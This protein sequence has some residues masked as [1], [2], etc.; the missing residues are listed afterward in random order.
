MSC[1]RCPAMPAALRLGFQ[2]FAF[3]PNRDRHR[4]DWKGVRFRIATGHRSC[5]IKLPPV[6]VVFGGCAPL[7]PAATRHKS[8]AMQ[9]RA[10]F[11][12][13]KT[14]IDRRFARI[15]ES[16]RIAKSGNSIASILG[17]WAGLR[18]P[19]FGNSLGHFLKRIG[20]KQ[21]RAHGRRNWLE[22]P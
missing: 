5:R 11:R 22:H 13:V 4:N 8:K 20:W 12:I 19:I 2:N 18:G 1:G 15:V 21:A 6:K 17:F 9:G 7:T 14:R 3:R 16:Y 10:D